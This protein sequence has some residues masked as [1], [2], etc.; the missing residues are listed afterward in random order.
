MTWGLRLC[1][2]L[3]LALPW[4]PPRP[5]ELTQRLCRR[6]GNG[7]SRTSDAPAREGWQPERPG[8]DTSPALT[9]PPQLP[10]PTVQFFDPTHGVWMASTAPPA[11][12]LPALRQFL[13]QS[14]EQAMKS[15]TSSGTK[16]PLLEE[17]TETVA[18]PAPAE[19][20]PNHPPSRSF[21]PLER[22]SCAGNLSTS[23]ERFADVVEE[24]SK[25]KEEDAAEANKKK[26]ED[27]AQ[28]EHSK[29]KEEDVAE[30]GKK[31]EEDASEE[32][33]KP[34]APAAAGSHAAT[35]GK[36]SA[37]KTSRP[38]GDRS[39]RYTSGLLSLMVRAYAKRG[40]PAPRL[41]ACL[42]VPQGPAPSMGSDGNLSQSPAWEAFIQKVS[43]PERHAR[44]CE[45]AHSGLSK[46]QRQVL[47][48]IQAAKEQ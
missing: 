36:T 12:G 24:A 23:T 29:K 9:Q 13:L 46:L 15:L 21:S 32:Q 31:K 17:P 40:R 7:G 19:Q 28:A 26:E 45:F 22:G 37:A 41:C 44:N 10:Q 38:D 33:H 39:S 8:A 34:P 3:V 30:A 1:P 16:P 4:R 47:L 48:L 14:H 27:S 42:P 20:L 25:K 2:R 11:G 18:S 35:A 5:A 6:S 43:N